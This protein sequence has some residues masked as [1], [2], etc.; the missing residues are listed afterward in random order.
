[1]NLGISLRHYLR[2]IFFLNYSVVEHG[3]FWFAKSYKPFIRRDSHSDRKN[4]HSPQCL[5]W[6]PYCCLCFWKLLVRKS[7]IRKSTTSGF[8][9][10]ETIHSGTI[11]IIN[12]DLQLILSRTFSSW[13][14]EQTI[15]MKWRTFGPEVSPGSAYIFNENTL[16]ENN[17]SYPNCSSSSGNRFAIVSFSDRLSTDWHL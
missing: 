8:W 17:L 7:L 3:I 6:F 15:T 16:F 2:F 13:L 14:L 12:N 11:Y 5:W 1:M 4:P 9:F 10:L